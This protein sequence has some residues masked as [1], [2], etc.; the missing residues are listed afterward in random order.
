MPMHG[1]PL[2]L[3]HHGEREKERG[4]GEH[5]VSI[6]AMPWYTHTYTH[7]NDFLRLRESFV[8]RPRANRSNVLEKCFPPPVFQGTRELPGKEKR[9]GRREGGKKKKK[10]KK[11]KNKPQSST[12]SRLSHSVFQKHRPFSG[13]NATLKACSIRTFIDR[14]DDPPSNAHRFGH[15]YQKRKKKKK[16][17]GTEIERERESV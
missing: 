9:K 17:K 3:S 14:K 11:R 10:K 13:S 4:E 1:K 12:N 7:T 2:F 16:K 15:M 5:L 6:R 8:P